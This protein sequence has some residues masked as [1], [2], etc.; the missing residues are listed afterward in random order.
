[1]RNKTIVDLNEENRRLRVLL[2]EMRSTVSIAGPGGSFIYAQ[3]QLNG[4]RR[5]TSVVY[6]QESGPRMGV[7]VGSHYFPIASSVMHFD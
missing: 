7:H 3:G 2:K 1:M 5:G 6:E 4:D